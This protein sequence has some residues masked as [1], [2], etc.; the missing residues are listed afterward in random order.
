MKQLALGVRLRAH[1]VFASFATGQNSEVVAALEGMQ[2]N[3]CKGPG[4]FRK[5]D[6]QALQVMYGFKIKVDPSVAW[7]IPELTRVIQIEDM[8]VPI[9]NKR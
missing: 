7:A 4:F 8:N 1:A 3:T 5:E 2:M 6:H 9:R